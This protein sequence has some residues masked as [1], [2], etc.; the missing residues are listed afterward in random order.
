VVTN[1][2]E[3]VKEVRDL[4]ADKYA[5]ADTIHA[6]R[7]SVVFNTGRSIEYFVDVFDLMLRGEGHPEWNLGATKPKTQSQE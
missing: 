5:T 2:R 6:V 4:I 7:E 1:I 3:L